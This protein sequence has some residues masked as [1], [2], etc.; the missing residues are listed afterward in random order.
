MEV[1]PDDFPASGNVNVV[2]S[3]DIEPKFE[4]QVRRHLQ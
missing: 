4:K 2:E 3:V 1:I